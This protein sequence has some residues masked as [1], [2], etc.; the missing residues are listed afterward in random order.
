MVGVRSGTLPVRDILYLSFVF[1][2][3]LALFPR[4][5]CSADRRVRGPRPDP[6][7]MGKP[8]A[9]EPEVWATRLFVLVLCFHKHSGAVP[10]KSRVEQLSSREVEERSPILRP[11]A[12]RPPSR[13]A[14]GPSTSQPLDS[15]TPGLFDFLTAQE[16]RNA[17][18]DAKTKDGFLA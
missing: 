18:R 5:W 6:A 7:N 16:E 13:P 17:G 4:F 10:S 11:E 1:I 2:N 8:Q 3:I 15:L 12:S 14:L 9:E